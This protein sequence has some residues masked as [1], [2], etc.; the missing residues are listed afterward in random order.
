MK[1]TGMATLSLLL[2]LVFSVAVN[3][4]GERDF[5]LVKLVH[6]DKTSFDGHYEDGGPYTDIEYPDCLPEGTAAIDIGERYLGGD[7]F[8]GQLQFIEIKN[9]ETF[10][11][12][13]LPLCYSTHIFNL[14]RDVRVYCTYPIEKPVVHH[15]L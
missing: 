3:A 2:F 13:H 4:R 15:R 5:R 11:R 7:C 10:W 8:Y 1:K 6:I 9:K 12:I 14:S